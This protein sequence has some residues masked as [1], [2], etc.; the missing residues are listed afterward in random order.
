[1]FLT[2]ERGPIMLGRI[3]IENK[4]GT[5][6]IYVPEAHIQFWVPAGGRL[7]L[8]LC[9]FRTD[10]YHR[11]NGNP[12]P[13]TQWLEENCQFTTK[14]DVPDDIVEF[15][16]QSERERHESVEGIEELF[17]DMIDRKVERPSHKD[18]K[19]LLEVLGEN[20]SDQ[21]ELDRIEFEIAK[22]AK[23]LLTDNRGLQ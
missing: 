16:V 21:E 15:A 6:W 14:V 10:G 8:I 11:N 2:D 9:A 12:I 22:R 20:T 19:T 23:A 5:R 18:L 13:V 3:L 4:D 7:G 1:M 17:L